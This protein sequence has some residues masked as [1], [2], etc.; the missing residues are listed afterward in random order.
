M[1]ESSGFSV[2]VEGLA[3]AEHGADDGD[4]ASWEGDE[5]LVVKLSLAALAVVVDLGERVA[6][7]DRAEGALEEDALE[8]AVAAVGTPPAAR[9]SGLPEV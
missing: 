9:F 3:V 1:R 2:R 4:A 8:R 7:D 6:G 5:S